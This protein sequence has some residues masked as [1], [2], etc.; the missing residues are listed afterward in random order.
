MDGRRSATE[1]VRFEH[2]LEEASH[3]SIWGRSVQAEGHKRAKALRLEGAWCVEG[4]AKKPAARGEWPWG[5]EW[6]MRS[7]K[8]PEADGYS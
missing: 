6:E 5:W 7:V 1:K 2:R 4:V 3:A 8:L